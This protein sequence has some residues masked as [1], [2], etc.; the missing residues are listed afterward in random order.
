MF[1]YHEHLGAPIPV[2]YDFSS[3][4]LR[5]QHAPVQLLDMKVASVNAQVEHH[6]PHEHVDMMNLDHDDKDAMDIL[7]AWDENGDLRSPE[8]IELDELQGVFDGYY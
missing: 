5:P 8:D 2:T 6:V 3:P 4:V 7:S 1:P